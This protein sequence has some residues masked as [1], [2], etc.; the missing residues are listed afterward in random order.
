MR[1]TLLYTN[2]LLPCCL[3]TDTEMYDLGW[4]W[5]AWM[6]II[7][8]SIGC[9]QCLRPKMSSDIFSCSFTL[10][11][12]NWQ[13]RSEFTATSRGFL[14][15]RFKCDQLQETIKNSSYCNRITLTIGG[16]FIV[17]RFNCLINIC[18]LVGKN[19]C[20]SVTLN[21][22]TI[23]IASPH[24]ISPFHRRLCAFGLRYQ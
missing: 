15:T 4:L 21:I 7:R 18:T 8:N 16:P 9:G 6:F 12:P 17:K 14:A 10:L 13:N 11:L 23:V 20:S 1:R 19:K 3:S 2:Y 24:I 22:P 5:V